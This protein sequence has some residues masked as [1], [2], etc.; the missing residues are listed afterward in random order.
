MMPEL[1]TASAIG[2]TS[3]SVRVMHFSQYTCLPIWAAATV[4]RECQW[5]GVAMMTASTSGAA[6][7]SSK[8]RYRR[9]G[10]SWRVSPPGRIGCVDA[11]IAL[12]AR[13]SNTSHTAVSSRFRFSC[14]SHSS[15]HVSRESSAFASRRAWI[16][17]G[18]ANPRLRISDS[19]SPPNPTMPILRVSGCVR[20]SSSENTAA[21]SSSIPSSASNRSRSSRASPLRCKAV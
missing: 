21:P 4:M 19:P 2:H 5:S 17:S 10:F 14:W 1:F 3:S 18:C 15:S 13:T 9:A 12:S 6:T 8:W 16:Q 20:V 7:S 11:A